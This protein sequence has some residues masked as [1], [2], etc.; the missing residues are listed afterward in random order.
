MSSRDLGVRNLKLKCNEL[1][2]YYSLIYIIIIIC[3][4]IIMKLFFIYKR[5]I[6][7][8][9]LRIIILFNATLYIPVKIITIN[10]LVTNLIE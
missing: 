8:S 9:I 1:L 7:V 4:S 2:H 10:L 5:H 6:K 3:H